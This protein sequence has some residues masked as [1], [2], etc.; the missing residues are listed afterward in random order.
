MRVAVFTDDKRAEDVRLPRHRD[1]QGSSIQKNI[2]AI[3]LL[4]IGHQFR[5]QAESLVEIGVARRL[6]LKISMFGY[7]WNTLDER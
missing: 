2:A 1:Y 6:P 3:V 5:M 4:S 7:V